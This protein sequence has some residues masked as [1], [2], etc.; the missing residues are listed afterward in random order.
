MLGF[1]CFLSGDVHITYESS[2]PDSCRW[3]HTHKCRNVEMEISI[4]LKIDGENVEKT[5]NE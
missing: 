1:L 2:H 4:D 3:K 5:L